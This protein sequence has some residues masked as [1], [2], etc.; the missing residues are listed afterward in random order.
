[1][2]KFYFMDQEFSG[3][4]FDKIGGA[5][6]WECDGVEF[7]YSWE[8]FYDFFFITEPG[9]WGSDESSS[10][11]SHLLNMAATFYKYHDVILKKAALEETDIQEAIDELLEM[12]E[13]SK[14]H[15][16]SFWTYGDES[17]KKDLDEERAALPSEE[18]MAK[19]LTLPHVEY[20]MRRVMPEY[21]VMD[22]KMAL[23]RYRNE[24]ADFNRR[25]KLANKNQQR[26]AATGMRS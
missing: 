12:V 13:A 8:W 19:V 2:A 10:L 24:L 22:E 26:D 18:Q 14:G 23:K 11:R 20:R 6:I 1:M 4:H 7:D 25:K 17:N 21:F 3:T 5:A 16:V 15:L 9:G